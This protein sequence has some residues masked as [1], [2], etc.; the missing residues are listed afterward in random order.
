M[1]KME[2]DEN[3]FWL[4]LWAIAAALILLLVVLITAYQDRKQARILQADSCVKVVTIDGDPYGRA[5]ATCGLLDR[6]TP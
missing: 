5:L 6:R 1:M 4:I 3:T 2:T